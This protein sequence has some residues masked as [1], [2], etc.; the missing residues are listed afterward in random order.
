M[1]ELIAAL[2][3]VLLTAPTVAGRWPGPAMRGAAPLSPLFAEDPRLEKKVALRM[4]RSPLARVLAELARQTR[5]ELSSS[6]DVA[7]EPT[8][9]CAWDRP[10]KEVMHH[11]AVLFDYR[12]GRSGKPGQYAYRLYQDPESRQ[13][14]ED[15]RCQGRRLA[16]ERL[17]AR[18][19]RDVARAQNPAPEAGGSGSPSQ[20]S[21][22]DARIPQPRDEAAGT[23]LPLVRALI[24]VVGLLRPEQWQRLR[25]GE[26]LWFS[27]APEPG[28]ATLP[29]ALASEL[30]AAQPDFRHQL[31]I[32]GCWGGELLIAGHVKQME[33]A[34]QRAG[35][36][37]VRVRFSET[38]YP[39]HP[40]ACLQV[41]P[42]A[43]PRGSPETAVEIDNRYEVRE[44]GE[45]IGPDSWPIQAQD[46]D[47]VPQVWK[48]DP[49]IGS[50]RRL[51]VTPSADPW[52]KQD[53]DGVPSVSMWDFLAYVA[54]A[55]RINLVADA[56]LWCGWMCPPESPGEPP[57][58]RV[59]NQYV[60]PSSEW[61]REGV[62]FRIRSR[63]WFAERV[64]EIPRR[65]ADGW[66]ACLHDWPALS[67]P[68]LA[69]L[70]LGLSDAQFP[71][72]ALALR[73]RGV[74]LGEVFM[75]EVAG[76]G[77]ESEHNRS[78]L[79]VYGSLTP[80]QRQ[81]LLA[82]GA[83]PYAAMPLAARRQA[84]TAFASRPWARP[85][86]PGWEDP[87][88]GALTLTFHS[89]VRT[90]RRAPDGYHIDYQDPRVVGLD[91]VEESL[92]IQ[93]QFPSRTEVV[94]LAP[95][96]VPPSDGAAHQAEFTY[97]F[98]DGTTERFS[99][100]LPVAVVRRQGAGKLTVGISR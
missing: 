21:G 84:Q 96:A 18:V 67:L 82:G 25:Q 87:F 31:S 55:H 23:K 88:Q 48:E 97:R 4:R 36:I 75:E 63:R 69:D 12:W 2:L 42:I 29:A 81:V 71:H 37:R 38:L 19:R 98:A 90:V 83:V 70:A 13:R 3:A 65:V 33:D 28:A 74:Y 64:A 43:V 76:S 41:Q 45:N 34:W 85:Y 66:A 17:L 50:R 72:F 57:L 5:V 30:R 44:Y 78:I 11:L 62:W 56:Y 77:F 24:R 94:P 100:L 26:V 10:A 9:V 79:R 20:T 47:A 53:G 89:G 32:G 14:E 86:A 60:L 61:T 52:A 58:Y 93:I 35:S 59:L 46:P 7:D 68:Q 49:V 16:F 8:V 40:R 15:L 27:T 51:D 95:G 54:Q 91:E 80:R 73:E 6:A 22:S 99:F 1:P 39:D 92:A